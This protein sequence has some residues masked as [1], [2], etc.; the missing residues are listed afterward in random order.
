MS[1]TRWF[2]CSLV[3]AMAVVACADEETT[4]PAADD[5]SET[6]DAGTSKAKGDS[7]SG[8]VT[9]PREDGGTT[10]NPEP[11][12]VVDAGPVDSGPSPTGSSTTCKASYYETGSQ[13]ANGEKFDPNGLTAAHKT[14]PFN[15]MLR[16]KNPSNGKSVDVRINDR[17]PF[18]AGRCLDLARGAFEK[19][20]PLSAGV[21]T[22]EF[23]ELK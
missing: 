11:D 12:A 4:T 7:G 1:V 6:S 2:A 18:T 13:T 8:S 9:E 16:V 22:V 17:G 15:T 10:T 23:V 19:I 3:V 14:L 20:A 21:V 5:E